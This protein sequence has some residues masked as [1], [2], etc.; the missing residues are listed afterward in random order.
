LKAFHKSFVSWV[1]AVSRITQGQAI[2]VDGKKP[3]GWQDKG[4]GKGAIDMVSAWAAE[5][6]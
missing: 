4:V 5:N 1:Q 3:R 2:A 6:Q